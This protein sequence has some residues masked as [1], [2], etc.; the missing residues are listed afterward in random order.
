MKRIGV[1]AF[2]FSVYASCPW[3]GASGTAGASFP[4]AGH[5]ALERV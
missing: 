1:R 5:V 4:Q 2:V 3:H